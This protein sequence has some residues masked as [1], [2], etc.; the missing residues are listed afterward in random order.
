VGV[1]EV[2]VVAGQSNAANHGEI[3]QRASDDRVVAYYASRWRPAHDPMPGA[4]GDDGS[5]WPHLGDMLVRS[6]Q[7]P[8]GFASVAV[9]G[10]GSSFWMP[11]AEGYDLLTTV[12]RELGPAGARAVLWHQGESDSV[13]GN[14]AEQY[15]DNLCAIIEALPRD[16]GWCPPWVVAGVSMRRD[17]VLAPATPLMGQQMLWRDGIAYEGPCTDDMLGPLYRHDMLHF[18]EYGLR[19]HAERW[20]AM[21][22]AQLYANVPLAVPED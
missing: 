11:G 3:P 17:E 10:T 7:V 15:Y 18:S 12:L 16:V 21:L 6:L 5:P 9:G 4:S 13:V 19:V 14:T 22:W 20:F 8:I 2:F 1:G